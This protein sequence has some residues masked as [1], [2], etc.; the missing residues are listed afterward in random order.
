MELINEYHSPGLGL[1]FKVEASLTAS[2]L[3]ILSFVQ[4]FKRNLSIY[5]VVCIIGKHF[6]NL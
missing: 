3:V 1:I 4:I 2:K 6:I 5:I